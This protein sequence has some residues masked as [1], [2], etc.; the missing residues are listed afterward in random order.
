M[1]N[2]WTRGPAFVIVL[3]KHLITFNNE[4]CQVNQCICAIC[5]DVMCTSRYW[6][7]PLTTHTRHRHLFRVREFCDTNRKQPLSPPSP[8]SL[9]SSWLF[10]NSLIDA[11]NFYWFH[12]SIVRLE[13]MNTFPAF[14][15]INSNNG[16][17]SSFRNVFCILFWL[18]RLMWTE[19]PRTL[20][21]NY[22]QL[23]LSSTARYG[24]LKIKGKVILGLN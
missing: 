10:H 2:C 20:C 24:R 5:Y 11:G 23:P 8:K 22:N 13:T 21:Y 6:H 15:N 1:E 14:L 4:P 18:C 7:K 16:R 9:K 12:W 19:L 17:K 3:A